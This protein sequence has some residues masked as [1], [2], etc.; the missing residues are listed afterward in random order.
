MHG[1][2]CFDKK[3][4]PIFKENNYKTVTFDLP[5]CGDDYTPAEKVD[6]QSHIDKTLSV[7]NE[8]VKE[9]EKIILVAHS[10]GG[11]TAT[12][13]AERIPERIHRVVYLSAWFLQDGQALSDMPI[14]NHFYIKKD[15]ESLMT[16]DEK[17]VAGDFFNDCSKEDIE[18]AKS[19]IRDQPARVTTEKMRV[20]GIIYD[21]EKYYISTLQDHAIQPALQKMM[22]NEKDIEETRC[23]G[24]KDCF[25]PH[26]DRCDQF[27]YCE[28]NADGVTGRPIVKDCP[29]SLKW[30]DH[31]KECGWPED[32]TCGKGPTV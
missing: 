6:L 12:L 3:L 30:D 5:G 27:I 22:Y 8:R 4:V 16:M 26:P 18:F 25:Y 10:L 7:I 23:K 14:K 31:N 19:K 17:Y 20:K 2:W 28:V 11:L 24:P 32:S 15:N 29:D 9:D 13:V 21:L 1:A